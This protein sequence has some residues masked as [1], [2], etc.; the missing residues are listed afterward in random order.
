MEGNIHIFV[1]YEE[2]Y[3]LLRKMTENCEFGPSDQSGE[4]SLAQSLI[5]IRNFTTR[6][7]L[8]VAY[9]N[10]TF[11][12]GSG[13]CR[14]A[15]RNI[16]ILLMR[17]LGYKIFVAGYN[18]CLK[19]ESGSKCVPSIINDL[20][21]NQTDLGLV[22]FAANEKRFQLL[23]ISTP[24]LMTNLIAFLGVVIPDKLTSVQFGFLAIFEAEI[25][26]TLLAGICILIAVSSLRYWLRLKRLIWPF[27]DLVRVAF[28][29]D[30][31]R[32]RQRN[33]SLSLLASYLISV[34]ILLQ[35]YQ[36]VLLSKISVTPLRRSEG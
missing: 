8:R 29:K 28:G 36:S 25:W 33:Y 24:F 11:P 6:P 10:S 9:E 21:K 23:D 22:H 34:T 17:Q 3:V 27:W 12:Q 4:L 20:L 16:L 14:L 1:L 19:K 2:K 26:T 15:E 35:C 18:N 32:R 5:Q 7:I 30:L 13:I 31:S